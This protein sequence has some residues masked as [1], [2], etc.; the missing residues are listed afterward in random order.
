MFS[1]CK[2]KARQRK[3]KR[4]KTERVMERG[5][6]QKQR[7]GHKTSQAM[8]EF[9]VRKLLEISRESTRILGRLTQFLKKVPHLLGLKLPKNSVK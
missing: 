1:F 7:R 8:L 5:N 4:E 2:D 9:L 3:R 6:R